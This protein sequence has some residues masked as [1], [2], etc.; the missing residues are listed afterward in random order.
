MLFSAELFWLPAL[1]CF[2]VPAAAK[3]K[4]VQVGYLQLGLIAETLMGSWTELY[5]SCRGVLAAWKLCLWL[6]GLLHTPSSTCPSCCFQAQGL[7]D[8]LLSSTP[9]VFSFF[10]KRAVKCLE[11]VVLW[12]P[13]SVNKYIQAT[14]GASKTD[15]LELLASSSGAL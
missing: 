14:N 8:F 3:L 15:Q 10:K 7:L 6:T 4:T 12:F 9:T 5:R 2:Y 13:N 11:Q 1:L